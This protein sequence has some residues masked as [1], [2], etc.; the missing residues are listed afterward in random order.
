[1]FSDPHF[2]NTPLWRRSSWCRS[3]KDTPGVWSEVPTE[4][5][6]DPPQSV[7]YRV[8][9]FIS[10]ILFPYFNFPLVPLLCIAH[11]K[12]SHGY[13]TKIAT[14]TSTTNTLH[15]LAWNVD[16]ISRL[17]VWR[18]KARA[19][20]QCLLD[21]LQSDVQGRANLSQRLYRLKSSLHEIVKGFY[22]YR[23]TAA[24]HVLVIMIS[25]ETQSKKPYAL[26]IQCIPYKSL[27][28]SEIRDILNSVIRD[29]EWRL[30]VSHWYWRTHG[31]HL[32]IIM[33]IFVT[34][35]G[36]QRLCGAETAYC[37]LRK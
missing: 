25:I 24:T 18:R 35:I 20:V 30:Q 6:R 1:M 34:K 5:F 28:D 21:T 11:Q 31:T 26:P 10:W 27:K 16:E 9:S 37:V 12:V 19:E 15:Q 7:C 3:P 22:C 32:F 2:N 17:I 14:G 8:R 36:Q 4:G 13:A 29:W 23:R 33:P